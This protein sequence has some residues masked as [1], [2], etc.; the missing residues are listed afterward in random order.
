MRLTP[1]AV[2][3][4]LLLL[5]L[6]TW[7]AAAT[8]TE[9]L[10]LSVLPAPGPVA[11]DGKTDDWDLSGGLF[12]C[13]DC[14]TQRDRYAVWFHAMYDADRLYVLARWLDPE[15]LNN[16][17]SSKGDLVFNGDCLQFRI[18]SAGD[19]CTHWTCY[20]DREGIDLMAIEYG[21]EFNEG[22]LR[23]AKTQ[24]GTQAF[25]LEKGKGYVQELAIPWK[26][27][28][29][30]GEPTPKAGDRFTL[31]IEPNFT[32]VAGRL[33][34]KDNFKPGVSIDRLFTFMGSKCWGTATL[35]AKGKVAPR[36]VRLAD[37]REFPVAMADGAP[38]IDW[39]GLIKNKELPGFK[40]VAFTLPADGF[41]SLILKDADGGVV[42]HLLNCAFF[43]Q[44]RH[45]VKWDGNT[46]Y[47]FRTPGDPVPAGAYSYSAIFHTGIGLKLRGFAGCDG[48]QP[49][50]AGTTSAWGGDHG[51][52][53]GAA[54]DGK[55]VY[56]G[57]NGAEAGKALLACDLQGNV[58]WRNT[59]GGI[60]GADLIAVDQGTV[61]V[62][63]HTSLYRVTA[64]KGSY[65]FWAGTESTDLALT[66]LLDK[67][68][69]A[70]GLA[71]REGK[72]YVSFNKANAIVVADGA[73]GKALKKIDI[74]APGQ[75]VMSAAG[76][77]LAVSEGKAVLAI[78][79]QSGEAKPVVGG[80]QGAT[81]LA[82]DAEG[83][84][85]VGGCD[86]QVKVF[87]ADGK[88]E[89]T[90]GRKGGRP[91]IGPWQGDGMAFIASLVVDPEGKLWV[92]EANDTPKRISVWDTKSGKRLKEFFGPTHYGASGGAINPRD[93]NLMVGQGCEW[94]LDPKTGLGVCTG[95]FE[96]RIAG[97]ARFCTPAN[98]KLYLVTSQSTYA[99]ADYRIYERV[100]EGDYRLR[101]T[102]QFAKAEPGT[103]AKESVRIWS[104]ANG[105]GQPQANEVAFRNGHFSAS[106]YIDISAFVN[107]DLSFC[108]QLTQDGK[109]RAVRLVP[110]G[111]TA[112]GAPT[113]DLA[114]AQAIPAVGQPSLDNRFLVEWQDNWINGYDLASGKLRWRYPNTFSGVHGSHMASG[115]EMGVLR[116]SFGVIGSAVLA[117]PLGSIWALN[118]NCGEWYVFNEDGFFVTKLFQGDPM[119]VQWPEK[120]V[121]GTIL[122]N[123][124]PGLGGEDFGGS[125]TQGK[126]GNLYVQAGKIGLWNVEVTGMESVQALAGGQVSL[127]AED[128]KLAQAFHDKALQEITGIR[129]HEIARLVPTFTG[130][131]DADF[132]GAQVLA[133]QKQD[134]SAV[135]VASAYDDTTLYVA[136]DVKD[137]TPWTNGAE[138]ADQMYLCGDTV[139]LQLATDSKADRKREEAGAGDLRLSIGNLKGKATAVLYRRV[140]AEKKPRSYHSGVVKD[141]PMDYVDA[142]EARILVTV[143]ERAGT[144]VEAAIPLAALG[145]K[146]AAGQTL[147]GDFGVTL[148]DP[149]GKRTRLRVYWNNQSTGIVD[150]AVF[151]LK[152]EPKNWGEVIF[153]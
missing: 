96:Q 68:A 101:A 41:V 17:Y 128:V 95:V 107:T 92:T 106:G 8:P 82:V 24:G 77:L 76:R 97:F 126:D 30:E 72:L 42:R 138:E 43:T 53:T 152:M 39:T 9:N 94:K 27:L 146:P 75:L 66:S 67:A 61:Y 153:K 26:L 116:G 7:A 130:N 47:V 139:D 13:D 79:P 151:E 35:E 60:G 36:A 16:P 121:P 32:L 109:S 137:N 69:A 50:D 123:C 122:D 15:P 18:I 33:T 56:L 111:F 105:D 3:L 129:R 81:G 37:G 55:Q 21:R 147:T 88:E 148:G 28:L 73:S 23:D 64:D 120:A 98:G 103:A 12:T 70:D 2:A 136:W 19:R 78:D 59:R 25:T 14:E 114:Q 46:D 86:N 102:I 58:L 90:I 113:Y 119:K 140:S 45:E 57:W 144:L 142:V 108:G 134:D 85:Y 135:R 115:P 93:P 89:R 71:A 63:N 29:K 34:I 51:V 1:C 84:I 99:P 87:A 54:A 40:P 133:F 38:R 5:V 143:K 44:G 91:A 112:C 145:L 118:G 141:Y 48:K 124:P 49:W 132:K 74:A 80:L 117:K 6:P 131:L 149:A 100:G 22:N 52:P 125:F 127:D 11:V 62:L 150:D 10:G 65:T 83:R 20:R 104:D 4:F 110:T 31:T